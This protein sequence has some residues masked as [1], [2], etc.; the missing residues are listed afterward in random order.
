[1]KNGH[2]NIFIY[3]TAANTIEPVTNDHFTDLYPLFINE[4]KEILFSSN[5]HQATWGRKS[6]NVNLYVASANRPYYIKRLTSHQVASHTQAYQVENKRF[7]F[8]N[9]E[10]G[11]R[12]RFIASLDSTISHVDTVIHYRYSTHTT[13]MSNLSRSIISHHLDTKTGNIA[14][15]IRFNAKNQTLLHTKNSL[16]LNEKSLPE[17]RFARYRMQAFEQG[18]PIPLEFI[19]DQQ[20]ATHIARRPVGS[21]DINNYIFDDPEEQHLSDSVFHQNISMPLLRQYAVG[22]TVNQLVT[23]I[24]P[25]Y[26]GQSYQPFQGGATPIYINP[27]LNALFKI[28]AMDMMEDYRLTAGIKVSPQFSNNEYLLSYENLKK[29]LDKQIVFHRR[30]LETPEESTTLRTQTNSMSFITTWPFSGV[31]AWKGGI[32]VRQDRNVL[33]ATDISSLQRATTYKYWTGFKSE[34]IFDNTRNP[35]TNIYFGNRWKIFFEHYLQPENLK[36]SLSVA[37]FDYRYYLPIHR[38]LIWANRIGGSTSFGKQLLIYYLGGVDSWL[39]P[40]FNEDTEVDQSENYA[41]QT[42]ATNLRG[43]YQN[44]RNGNSFLVWNSEVRFPVFSY[45]LN[46]PIRNQVVKDF[47]LT[48]FADVGSAWKGINPYA[49]ENIYSDRIIRAPGTPMTITLHNQRQPWVAGF[50]TGLRTTLMGY[51]IRAD[52]AWL[53][54]E[55]IL[56]KPVFYLSLSLDF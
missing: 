29:R 38:N 39:T 25:G 5:R 31:L 37:G 44:T 34:I 24:D 17:T 19:F 27:G 45:L 18:L 8:L 30:V 35:A 32:T 53:L 41:W 52:Y 12:N 3:N 2:T 46:R 14:D 40:G 13:P 43:G 9:D 26:M 21:I 47:Q 20:K 28:G 42:L 50:G 54:D 55:G 23:Q 16:N 6:G 36:Q 15:N 1:L 51:F 4:G 48:A 56:L 7:I 22:F 49:S 33:L 11:I 10:N